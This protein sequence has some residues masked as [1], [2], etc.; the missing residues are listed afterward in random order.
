MLTVFFKK[1]LA[2]MAQRI[3]SY[4]QTSFLRQTLFLSQLTIQH[5]ISSY[6]QDDAALPCSKGKPVLGLLNKL[7]EA[8]CQLSYNRKL[9]KR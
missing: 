8:V 6:D 7:Y 2:E 1:R 9:Q 4:R 3:S 5:F